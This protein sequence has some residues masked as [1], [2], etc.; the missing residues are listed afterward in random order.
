MPVPLCPGGVDLRLPGLGDGDI[1]GDW[2]GHKLPNLVIL[3]SE[4]WRTDHPKRIFSW[5][6]ALI[7]HHE[8]SVTITYAACY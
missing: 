5:L 7:N 2:L 6:T 8:P 4:Q 1:V 3:Q